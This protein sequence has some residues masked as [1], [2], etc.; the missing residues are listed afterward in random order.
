M[1]TYTV[2]EVAGTARVSVRPLQHYHEIGLLLPETS[3]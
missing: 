3:C 1:A 2:S